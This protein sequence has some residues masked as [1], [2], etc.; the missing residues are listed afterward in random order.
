MVGY[1]ILMALLVI[2]VGAI[3]CDSRQ[4]TCSNKWRDDPMYRARVY[5]RL[6]R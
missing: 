4:P 6:Y 3:Y 2:L 5:N 1:L